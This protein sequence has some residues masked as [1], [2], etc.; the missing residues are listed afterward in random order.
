MVRLHVTV[1][2]QTA[3]EDCVGEHYRGQCLK[4]IEGGVFRHSF[5]SSGKLAKGIKMGKSGNKFEKALFL[6]K[7]Y[8][9]NE[10]IAGTTEGTYSSRTV[11]RLP[12]KQQNDS[13][14][15]H[16]LTGVPWDPKA[17]SKLC[18]PKKLAAAVQGLS[19]PPVVE[20]APLA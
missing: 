19:I 16:G 10:F 17:T 1:K 18:R 4:C 12:L 11:K 13:V 3:Y 6:G 5:S 15:I 14:M 2:R 9:T 7:S 20:A 8:D